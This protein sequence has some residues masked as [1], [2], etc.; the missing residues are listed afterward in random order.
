MAIPKT[1]ANF[2]TSLATKI[3]AT[4]TSLTL[5]RSTDDDGGTLSGQYL[6]TL[7]EGG[8]D[9][10]H[11]IVTATGAACAID[12]RGL[13][14][15]DAVNSVAANQFEHGR[16]APAK[17]TNIGLIRVINR[18][19]G[20]EAFDSVDWTG[21]QSVDGLVTPTAGETTKA[22]NVDYVN[23]VAI[24]G[25]SDATEVGK[26]IVQIAT[27]AKFDAGDDT[28]STSATNVPV[29]SQIAEAAQD[30]R[31]TYQGADTGAADAYAISVTPNLTA[32]AEGQRFTFKAA[33][34]NT[35]ALRS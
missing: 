18:L 4:A 23:N 11:M 15:V 5:E 7:D 8:N 25:A 34:A 12:V 22:A 27:D 3:S 29:P 16:G 24:A 33:N 26:G 21:V 30:N 19:N 17:M 20:D 31:F 2:E 9:E 35:G 1:L 6:L 28:G 14:R 13:S 32:Y 10:E